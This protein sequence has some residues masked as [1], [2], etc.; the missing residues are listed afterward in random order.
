V[1]LKYTCLKTGAGIYAV[2]TVDTVATGEVICYNFIVTLC[3][4]PQF[5]E[6]LSQGY[7]SAEQQ[8]PAHEDELIHDTVLHIPNKH[9]FM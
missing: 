1:G 2:P 3:S 9:S 8:P 6:M 7:C 4:L 5:A